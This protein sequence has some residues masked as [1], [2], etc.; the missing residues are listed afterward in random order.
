VIPLEGDEDEWQAG[1][2]IVRRI[3]AVL[4]RAGTRYWE[5]DSTD[6]TDLVSELADF[7]AWEPEALLLQFHDAWPKVKCPEGFEDIAVL[8]HAIVVQFGWRGDVGSNFG[9]EAIQER[10]EIIAA[11]AQ[12]AG[13]LRGDGRCYLPTRT[14]GTLLGFSHV[15]A[16]ILIRRLKADGIFQELEPGSS[17][18]APLIRYVPLEDR[19]KSEVV[20]KG[21]KRL[22]GLE[23]L[24]CVGSLGDPGSPGRLESP[25]TLDELVKESHVAWGHKPGKTDNSEN[26]AKDQDEEPGKTTTGEA[27]RR[28]WRDI[29]AA[30]LDRRVNR[31]MLTA[32]AALLAP[33]SSHPNEIEQVVGEGFKRALGCFARQR[34]NVPKQDWAPSMACHAYARMLAGGRSPDEFAELMEAETERWLMQDSKT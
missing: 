9:N 4:L 28:M 33:K 14:V 19:R 22:K 30:S 5:A 13:E 2:R 25:V 23:R 24:G 32:I 34:D 16:E 21:F 27:R 12:V 15:T 6:F 10:A 3:Q 26:L 17:T 11:M 29:R 8:A 1:F 7:H 20:S 31:A 18:K